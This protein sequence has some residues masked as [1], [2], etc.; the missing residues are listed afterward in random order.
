MPGEFVV[1][2]AG[3]T[4]GVGRRN[5]RSNVCVEPLGVPEPKV[6]LPELR[7]RPGVTP[8][9]AAI[10]G[11]TSPAVR[12]SLALTV[13]LSASGK[14]SGRALRWRK[15]RRPRSRA[16]TGL[17]RGGVSASEPVRVHHA[18]AP[19]CAGPA[20]RSPGP[21]IQ[22]RRRRSPPHFTTPHESVPS[23]TRTD[24]RKHRRG[25]LS[26]GGSCGAGGGVSG[27]LAG[28]ASSAVP[29]IGEK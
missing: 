5:A 8:A 22:N 28:T 7:T 21:R 17:L 16:R 9:R 3:R 24:I 25:I 27:A 6:G 4:R 10:F 1:Q 20:S 13:R 11:W 2:R 23:W 18:A 14:R 19:P 26:R 12:L 29:G 15:P